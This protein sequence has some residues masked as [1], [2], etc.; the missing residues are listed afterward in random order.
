MM[1]WIE[2]YPLPFMLSN[3][4]HHNHD[5]NHFPATSSWYRHHNLTW[6]AGVATTLLEG[7]DRD[8]I[9]QAAA[10]FPDLVNKP[11]VID[12]M[13]LQPQCDLRR[14]SVTASGLPVHL[15]H[16]TEIHN[17]FNVCV[18]VA[19]VVAMTQRPIPP[20]SASDHVEHFEDVIFMQR[21]RSTPAA[22]SSST[23]QGSNCPEPF[24]LQPECSNLCTRSSVD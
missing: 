18:R 15:I 24:A 1:C 10:S 4:D 6:V 3:R 17:G 21:S 9:M 16:Q 11:A 2:A 12:E 7:P 23:A 8:A 14:C 22:A 5:G 13:Q 19:S 20:G